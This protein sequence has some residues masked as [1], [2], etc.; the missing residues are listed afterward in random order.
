[1]KD[2]QRQFIEFAL[3]N[4]A[5]L[6]GEF[7]LKSGRISPY[8]FNAGLFNTGQAIGRLGQ[9]YAQAIL[10]A[11]I[12]FDMLFGPAYKGIPL[13]TAVAIALAEHHGI[14]KPYAF[15]RKEIKTHGEGGNIVGSALKG[16]VL[17]IDDVI[18]AGITMGE[19]I[20][21]L[22]DAHCDTASI[23]ISM[24]RQER[25]QNNSLSTIA[26]VENTYHIPVISIIQLADLIKYLEESGQYS[27]HLAKIYAYNETYG[28]VSTTTITNVN[29]IE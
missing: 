2:Y 21:I 1:M 4:K 22:Q 15:N 26:E 27:E 12:S 19:S 10:A 3:E 9:F 20:K 13:V 5:L 7:K 14:N 8:F 25:M 16:R 24:D 23:I 28:V 17:I 29:A 18:T 11:G 6:L